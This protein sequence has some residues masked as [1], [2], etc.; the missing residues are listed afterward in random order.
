M[1][2][3]SIEGDL[4]AELGSFMDEME[5]S[6]EGKIKGIAKLFFTYQSDDKVGSVPVDTGRFRNS[7]NASVN[8]PDTSHPDI[9]NQ[10]SANQ[11]PVPDFNLQGDFEIGDTIHITN[12]VPYAQ[13]LNQGF[14]QQ[15]PDHFFETNFESAINIPVGTIPREND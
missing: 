1:A 4:E 3:A 15:V 13:K 12:G 11:F 6:V 7:W 8:E 2:D 10:H 14:V 5:E 9:S